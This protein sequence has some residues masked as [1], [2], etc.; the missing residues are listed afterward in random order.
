[1]Y[2]RQKKDWEF[3]NSSPWTVT[4]RMG[5]DP[6]RLLIYSPM[7]STSAP[8]AISAL[9]STRATDLSPR[10]PSRLDA[11]VAAVEVQLGGEDGCVLEA[12]LEEV[13]KA[14]H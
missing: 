10:T 4:L 6:P 9:F 3:H 1:M 13:V 5:R 11:A 7:L 14:D 2:P 12:E 8:V